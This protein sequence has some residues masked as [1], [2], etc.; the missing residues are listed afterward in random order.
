MRKRILSQ[1][2]IQQ[3]AKEEKSVREKYDLSFQYSRCGNKLFKELLEQPNDSKKLQQSSLEVT[4]A[5]A[6]FSHL[7]EIGCF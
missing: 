2:W 7:S 4:N 6:H 5:R 3:G 1:F